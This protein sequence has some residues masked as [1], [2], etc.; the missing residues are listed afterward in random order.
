MQF[1]PCHHLAQPWQCDSQKNTQH[2]KWRWRSPKC[3]ACHENC[4]SSGENDAKVMRLP[5]KTTIDTLWNTLDC[6]EVPVFHA[7]RSYTALEA[8]KKD[9]SCRTRH[10][11]GHTGLTRPPA[12]GCDRKRNVEQTHPQPPDPQTPRVKRGPLLRIRE[13]SEVSE[14]LY[15]PRH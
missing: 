9:R 2:V 5:H 12:N 8:S 10:R 13:H 6:H 1:A 14:P 11:H 15:A 4:Y 7:K 3:C